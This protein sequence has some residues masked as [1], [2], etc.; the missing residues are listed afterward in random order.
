MIFEDMLKMYDVCISDVSCRFL[1]RTSCIYANSRLDNSLSEHK[2]NWHVMTIQ[3]NLKFGSGRARWV[4][5]CVLKCRT[6]MG[7]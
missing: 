5:L 2:M 1:F 3:V 7:I 4:R 6:A